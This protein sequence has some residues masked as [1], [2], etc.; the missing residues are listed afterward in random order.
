MTA[1][2]GNNNG[3]GDYEGD[4]REDYVLETP[5]S[6]HVETQKTQKDPDGDGTKSAL[7]I[8]DE[9]EEYEQELEDQESNIQSSA[10]G[11]S[12]FRSDRTPTTA[13]VNKK[14]YGS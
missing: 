9:E 1:T 13:Q 5:S 4:N 2:Q 11:S 6:Q 3:N 7:D 8:S 10:K 14:M 12:K